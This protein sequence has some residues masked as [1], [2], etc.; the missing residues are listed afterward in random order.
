MTTALPILRTDDIEHEQASHVAGLSNLA[1]LHADGIV[2]GGW[3]H[4]DGDRIECDLCPRRCV[5]KDGDRGFCFVRQNLGGQMMLTTYGRSTGFCIDPI[6]KKPL[7]HF[8]PG[9]SVLS[10]GTAGC[11]LGCKFCQNWDISKSRETERLSQRALPDEIARAALEMGCASVAY[12]Y[13]DPVIW[14]EYAIDTALACKELGI[15][16]VAVTAGYITPEAR[17]PFY[18]FMDAANVDLKAF[19]EEF[20]YRTTLSHLQP[21]L[22]TLRW[23]KHETNVWFEITNLV[24]PQANDE[25]EEFRQMSDWILEAVGDEVPLHFSAFHPDFRMLD[26][27]R[28]PHETLITARDIAMKAG[29]KYVYVGNVDDVARQSTYCPKCQKLL[30]ERN[31]YELGEYALNRDN[32]R[33]CGTHIAG[34]FAT[35]PGNWGRKRQP[36][37]MK[38]FHSPD[39]DRPLVLPERPMSE[40]RAG[41]V[42]PPVGGQLTSAPQSGSA[43]RPT[44]GLTPPA[45]QNNSESITVQIPKT[46]PN[47]SPTQ[48]QILF[49]TAAELVRAAAEGRA[50][51]T[52]AFDRSGMRLNIVSG[53]FVSLKRHGRLRSCCG[54]FGQAMQL[55]QCL[56]EAAVRTATNDPRFPKV[57][58]SELPHLDLDVWLL[59]AP[60]QVS[61]RGLD[62]INAVTIG[63]HG[64]QIIRGQ[65]RGLLLPGV[66]TDNGW[67]SEEFLNQV[68]VKA[69]LPP[70]AWKSDDTIL[71]RFEGDVIHGPMSSAGQMS[72][73]VPPRPLLTASEFEQLTNFAR[74]SVLSL[75][76]GMTPLY[77]CPGVPDA[78]VHGVAVMITQPGTN[79]WL[80]VSRLSPK[81]KHPLQTTLF[82]QCETL[83]KALA[84]RNLPLDQLRVDILALDDTA[85]HGTVAEPDLTGIDSA[86][87]GVLVTERN[88]QGFV[89]DRRLSADQLVRDASQLAQVVA[90]EWSQLFSLRALSSCD[91]FTVEVTPKPAAG[92]DVRLPAVAGKFYPGD[93]A[94][95]AAELDRMLSNDSWRAGGVGP[96]VLGSSSNAQPTGGL[97][98]PARLNCSAAMVPHAGWRFSGKLAADVLKRIELPRTVIVIGPKHTANGLDWSVAPNRVWSF[99]GGQL[100]SD[101]ELARAL[102]AAIPGLQFDAAAHQQEHGI[103]VELPIIHRLA[104]QTKVVGICVSGATLQRCDDFARGLASVL[105]NYLDPPLLLISSDMNHFADDAETRRL[106]TLALAEFDRLNE[107]AL[108]ET[109]QANHISMCGLV[110]AVIVMKTLK[111]LGRLNRSIEVGYATSAEASGDT[112]RCVGYAGRL[113]V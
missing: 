92:S 12:T 83:A 54:S 13:N 97:P 108:F 15:K 65:Q 89:F 27:P 58:V 61:E 41:G 30:I 14:A 40:S 107:D 71:F 72:V 2:P 102:I 8:L 18:Q 10:F 60:E 32:C 67:D 84:G 94:G 75:L 62:R 25:L 111:K 78:D 110:P 39:R 103:E 43:P 106:D 37:D 53:T 76:S 87:R 49:A 17:G 11:N 45:R 28:T 70:T 3:W 26:R 20:Y 33:H 113:L 19:T 99:P 38:Q 24:I 101:P 80:S 86:T 44:G 66:A 93:A 96:P 9:T 77:F 63:K 82:T 98:P 1:A 68:C 64:L 73:S 29:L 16:S 85:M 88:K 55:N 79:F 6:E 95:V 31:W 100:E 91:R 51:E 59:F 47:L 46:A 48:R 56:R 34:V 23:L 74:Q 22:D 109:C 57:S 69:G 112:S 5:M 7:N 4:R 50:P 104:P 105:E 42:S 52:S 21:V 35:R 36:V 90:P 81:E